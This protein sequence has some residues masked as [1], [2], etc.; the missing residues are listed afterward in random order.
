MPTY[1]YEYTRKDGKTVRVTKFAVP[2]EESAKPIR[3]VDKTDGRRY[4]ARRIMSIT[5][6]MNHSWSEDVNASDLPPKHY[7]PEDVARDKERR[8]GRKASP[9]R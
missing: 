1:E 5:A 4:T 7:G 2:V 9:R 6:R 3:V 8:K